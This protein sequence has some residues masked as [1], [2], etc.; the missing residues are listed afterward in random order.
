MRFH[1]RFAA[2]IELGKIRLMEDHKKVKLTATVTG[3]G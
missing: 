1:V 2:W 3:S